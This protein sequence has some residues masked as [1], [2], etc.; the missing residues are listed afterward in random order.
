MG[1]KLLVIGGV[2]AGATAAARARRI[3]ESAEI[4]LLERGPHVSYANCGLPYFLSGDIDKRSKLLLQTPEGF[5][6]RYRVK[7]LVGTEA[8]EI[9]RAAKRVRARGPEGETTVPYDKLILAQGGAPVAP[10]VPGAG[11][12]QV[13]R[14]WTVSDMDRIH[15]YI[16]RSRP[17]TA[18]VVGGGFVGLEMAEAF[19]KRGLETTVVEVLPSV[20]AA[21]DPPFGGR[22]ERELEANGVRVRTGKGVVRFRPEDGVA[23]LSDGSQVPAELVLFSVGVRPE[24][25]LAR[26]AGLEVGPSGGLVVNDRLETSD[27]DIY[28]A[29][30]MVEVHHKVS[31]RRARLPL[32]G[33]AN[34]QGRIAASNALGLDL[35]YGGALGTSVV[36]VFEATAAITGLSERSAR[37]AGFRV[38]VA[39][40]H[41][42][43]HAG[44]FP[45]AKELA[46]KLVYDRGTSRVL[47]AQA[48]GH[49][50][51]EKRIDAVAMALQREMTLQ[52]LSEVDLS[53][54]P[55]YSSAND[56]LNI[57][58]FVGA[59]DVSGFSPLATAAEL[60]EALSSDDVPLVLDVR[61]RSEFERSHLRGACHIPV[62]ALRVEA[63]KLPRDRRIFVHCRS[64]FRAHLALR[65]L[66]ERGF[67]R[68]L[69][70]TGG[71]LAIQAEGGF[72]TEGA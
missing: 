19:R 24:L 68:V 30:D 21:M 58:A 27:P 60:K 8:F 56:P 48:F 16:A 65:I 59:N 29:G 46:L 23:E 49:A 9:D 39:E 22:I 37:E 47:G 5:H 55:P 13:F 1:V 6:T 69:N 20:M 70:V 14:L 63:E 3:S 15:D 52:D 4:T 31:G 35:R 40:I 7:V 51:V 72:E 53:Y 25:A 50:G 44:Y 57:A 2:A 42:E 10:G 36:K 11:S 62:D 66:V 18:L 38:G 64:G 45:G 54:A 71:Y 41:K 32:A 17:R 26:D 28:A 12:P 43:H 67:R 34:R 61:T 33:P